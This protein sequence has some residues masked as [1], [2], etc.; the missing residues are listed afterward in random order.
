MTE[1]SGTEEWILTHS[2]DLWQCISNFSMR[3]NH[4]EVLLKHRLPGPTHRISD[5]EDQGRGLWIAFLISFHVM[6]MT[7]WKWWHY[8][9]SAML[10]SCSHL[11][12]ICE[13][14]EELIKLLLPDQTFLPSWIND[15]GRNDDIKL[16]YL[17]PNPWSKVSTKLLKKQYRSYISRTFTSF[18]FHLKNILRKKCIF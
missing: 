8:S 10:N 9:L 5:T 6:L 14:P 2:V 7:L 17:H 15:E 3:Q 1:N 12:C 16:R 11:G 18:S 4:L 13:S